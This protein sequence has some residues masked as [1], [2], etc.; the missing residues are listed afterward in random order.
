MPRGKIITGLGLLA[1]LSI[2]NAAGGWDGHLFD[3]TAAHAQGIVPLANSLVEQS[4][5]ASLIIIT[6]LNFFAW[7]T[8]SILHLIIDPEFIFALDA[9]GADGPLLMMLRE[10]WQFTRDLVNIGFAIGLIIGAILMIVTAD[11]TKIKEHLPKFVMALVLVNFSWFVPRVIFDFSNVLT[12]TIYQIPT[13][14]GADGCSLPP[15][16]GEVERRPCVVVTRA[17]FLTRTSL[18]DSTAGTHDDGSTGWTCPIPRVVCIQKA[19]MDAAGVAVRSP[20]RILDGLVVNHARL[21][22]LPMVDLARPAI[23]AGVGDTD[24][25]GRLLVILAKLI[26]IIVLHAAIVFPLLAMAAAFFIR[27]PVLWITIAFMPIVAL[28]YV[29]NAAAEFTKPVQDNFIKAVFLPAK[30]A[31]PFVIGF[32]MLNAGA[33]LPAPVAAGIDI[34]VL[35]IFAGVANSWQFIWM[36]IALFIIWKFSF[37]ALRSD[38]AGVMGQ[39]TEKIQGMGSS[40]GSIARDWTLSQMRVIPF[41]GRGADGGLQWNRVSPLDIKRGFNLSAMR[42]ELASFGRLRSVDERMGVPKRGAETEQ[43]IRTDARINADFRVHVD[44]F[45][46]AAND[47][48]RNTSVSTALQDFRKRFGAEHARTRNSEVM[49]IILRGTGRTLTPEQQKQLE[50]AL[51]TIP[52]PPGIS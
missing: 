25:L 13:L 45:T 34:P 37:E 3:V 32:I 1:F 44:G 12:Y 9:G 14:L 42:S 10:I 20:A 41:P 8:M 29:F 39:F 31:V 17:E 36:C 50:A 6:L 19:R 2:L 23:P 40:L 5:R 47:A 26:L 51:K 28:G 30:V 16:P 4:S 15:G 35:P 24:A 22:W 43:R 38:K 33:E 52:E 18:V 21:Q 27:I 48:A 49:A 7:F 46:G 11:G